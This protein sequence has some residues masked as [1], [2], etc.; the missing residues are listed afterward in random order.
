MKNTAFLPPVRFQEIPQQQLATIEPLVRILNP[1]MTKAT[2][3]A[4]LKNMVADGYRCVGGYANQELVAIAGF[5]IFTRFWCGKQMDVDNVIVAPHYRNS[6]VGKKV[7]SWLE[8]AAKHEKCDII[9]LDS[10]A[11][12]QAAHRFYYREGFQIEGFHFCK[13][14]GLKD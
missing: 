5:K 14:I 10:Y 8:R 12:A 7:F 3:R 6:G 11:H 2:F 9:V 1:A 13:K 4:H